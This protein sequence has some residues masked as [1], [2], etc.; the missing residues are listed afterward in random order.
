LIKRRIK[1]PFRVSEDLLVCS[2]GLCSALHQSI[3][4]PSRYL[5]KP[6]PDGRKF[7]RSGYVSY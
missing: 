3:R 7:K 2:D 1:L 5:P 6:K 4:T